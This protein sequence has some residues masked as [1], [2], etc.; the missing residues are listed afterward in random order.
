MHGLS[1]DKL[2]YFFIGCYK[3]VAV[4][5]ISFDTEET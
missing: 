2:T 4:E 3:E 1:K 5:Y